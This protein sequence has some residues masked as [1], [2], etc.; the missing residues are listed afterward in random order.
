MSL[1]NLKRMYLLADLFSAQIVWTLFFIFRKV[2]IERFVYQYRVPIEL[3]SSF[4][5]GLF[6]IPVSWV[7]LY[8]MMGFYRNINHKT[9]IGDFGRTFQT[10]FI[11]ATV[12]FFVVILDD[13]V[14]SYRNYYYSFAVLF[15][16]Q[17][18]FT[19][20]F[21]LIL[22]S[23]KHRYI[24][25]GKLRFNTLI[26]GGGAFVAELVDEI[27]SMPKVKGFNI[28]G[29]ISLEN[30]SC[31]MQQRLPKLGQVENVLDIIE[32]YNITDVILAEPN[33]N[34]RLFTPLL[35]HLH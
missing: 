31:P 8:F 25:K 24:R 33:P 12:L 35:N 1:K 30:D 34:Q 2:I 14:G 7:L 9:R 16:L 3:S 26:I 4:Y 6:I 27:K 17:F 20:L 5:W 28:S 11:G 10:S 32:K 18:F 22:I 13:I 23:I 15:G 29:Y 21:R 19:F